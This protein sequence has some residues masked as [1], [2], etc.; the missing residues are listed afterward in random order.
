MGREEMLKFSFGE[1][2]DIQLVLKNYRYWNGYGEIPQSI[3]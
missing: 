2:T 1:N 3:R